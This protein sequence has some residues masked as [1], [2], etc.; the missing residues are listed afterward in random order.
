MEEQVELVGKA[1]VDHYYLLFDTSRPSLS[2]LYQP[3]S[4]LTFEGQKVQGGDDIANKLN[5]LPFEHCKHF[6]TTIDC[7]PSSVTGGILVFVSGNLQLAGEEHHL[8]FSQVECHYH[9]YQIALA[10]G[11]SG[12][13]QLLYKRSFKWSI[14]YDKAEDEST[15]NR[16]CTM[17]AV[18]KSLKFSPLGV[19]LTIHWMPGRST[20]L[21]SDNFIAF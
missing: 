2:S 16:V 13:G 4:M 18:I 8:K 6:I 3:T 1:F 14:G 20:F 19:L 9:K 10:E 15:K 12:E 21:P 7:Q 5:Q 17:A 11:I